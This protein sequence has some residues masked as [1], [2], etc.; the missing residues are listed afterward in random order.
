M[1]TWHNLIGKTKS[2]GIFSVQ[3]THASA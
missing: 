1:K 3:C 2:P